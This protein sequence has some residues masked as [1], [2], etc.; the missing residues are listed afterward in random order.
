MEPLV[1]KRQSIRK[2]KFFVQIQ[3]ILKVSNQ[4]TMLIIF[5]TEKLS[6][7][8][9]LL[10]LYHDRCV[11][12]PAPDGFGHVRGHS[13]GVNGLDITV[14]DCKSFIIFL[15]GSDILLRFEMYIAFLLQCLTFL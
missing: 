14:P 1:L 6:L 13:M 9:H 2:F 5:Q 3:L 10:M 4:V 11:F 12:Y 15:N 7:H 8:S